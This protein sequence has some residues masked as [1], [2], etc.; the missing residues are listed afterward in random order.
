MRMKP[1]LTALLTALISLTG[2]GSHKADTSPQT[3]PTAAES[4]QAYTRQIAQVKTDPTTDNAAK[5]N[6]AAGVQPESVPLPAAESVFN[7]PQ[8]I[9]LD[10]MVGQINGKAVYASDIFNEIG[11]E[12]LVRIGQV[13]PRLVFR[14]QSQRLIHETIRSRVFNA[15]IIA[16]AER[17][18]SEQEQ[19]GLLGFLK[20]ERE[21]LLAE[22]GGGSLAQANQ[23]L[24]QE[25]GY[26]LDEALENKRKRVLI[27]KYLSEKLG[28]KIT[29]NRREVERYYRDNPRE[30]N[31]SPSAT[32]RVIIVKTAQAADEV[33]KAL[34]EGVAFEDAAKK[35]S[36]ARANEG[37]LLPT[38][39]LKGPLSKFNE[40]AWKELNEKVRT[41]SVGQ[42]SDRT[43]I[44]DGL[45]WVKLEKLEGG[46]SRSL[47]EASLDIEALLRTRKYKDLYDKYM[48]DLLEN[49]NF[50][51][52]DEMGNDLLR[53]AM[54]RYA[55]AE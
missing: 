12:Q 1:V 55:K 28:P 51:P 48:L 26:G 24:R 35:Y 44:G 7:T 36:T 31:P 25:Q 52:L 37:G 40:L 41:L 20:R 39:P 6:Q 45:G 50:T 49:G 22:Y 30:F 14:E 47:Q 13:N 8:R 38:F 33:D 21:K 16:E 18:L 2:C 4:E 15:L 32:V 46:D 5:A 53:V 42:H 11:Q 10:A 29:V 27:E 43:P 23:R 54:D 19:L 17:N 34:A 9:I 3:T